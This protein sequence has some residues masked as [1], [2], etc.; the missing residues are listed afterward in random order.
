M[1]KNRIMY[2]SFDAFNHSS[3]KHKLRKKNTFV[4]IICKDLGSVN[5]VEKHKKVCEEI[6][7]KKTVGMP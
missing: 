4:V 2:K 1:K 7:G 5:I 6:N 3:T